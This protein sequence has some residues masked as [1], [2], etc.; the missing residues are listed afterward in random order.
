MLELTTIIFMTL[1][2][3]SIWGGFIYLLN[4]AYRKENR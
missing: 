3:G 4:R 2:L 1:I